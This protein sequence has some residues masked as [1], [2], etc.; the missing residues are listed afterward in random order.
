MHV[1]DDDWAGGRCLA[2]HPPTS[3]AYATSHCYYRCPCIPHC[4]Y[5]TTSQCTVGCSCIPRCLAPPAVCPLSVQLRGPITK[6][7]LQ[8][9]E[10]Q[11]GPGLQ[12]PT[13]V[14]KFVIYCQT[15]PRPWAPQL[16][17]APKGQHAIH[18]A[19]TCCAHCGLGSRVC[20]L[21]KLIC[22]AA[23]GP[24]MVDPFVCPVAAT[25]GG[26]VPELCAPHHLHIHTRQ[27]RQAAP[28]QRRPWGDTG[29][30]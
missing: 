30:L 10:G 25:P 3:C 21:L 18:A 17:L 23:A 9:S 6:P 5:T 28:H 7:G 1:D 14:M 29:H 12:L 11:A 26:L 24:A 16:D 2:V 27:C 8:Q 4:L 20:P 13:G 22:A 19:A 15:C